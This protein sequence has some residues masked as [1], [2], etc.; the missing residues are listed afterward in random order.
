MIYLGFWINGTS[1]IGFFHTN[2][3]MTMQLHKNGD[4]KNS[5]LTQLQKKLLSTELTNRREN[6]TD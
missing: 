2:I 1:K 5:E 6:I 4:N 3:S